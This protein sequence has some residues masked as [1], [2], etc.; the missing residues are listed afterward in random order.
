MKALKPL[1]V[2]LLLALLPGP[3]RAQDAES[4]RLDQETPWFKVE[5]IVFRNLG[6]QPDDEVFTPRM[7]PREEPELTAD[8]AYAVDARDLDQS[9][10]NETGSPVPGGPGTEMADNSTGQ[11]P[12]T[13]NRETAG[14]SEPDSYLELESGPPTL[15]DLYF[16]PGSNF[17]L[18][19]LEE[20]FPDETVGLSPD[21]E[22]GQAVDTGGDHAPV[23]SEQQTSRQRL[24]HEFELQDQAS[25]IGKRD[26][27]R[28]VAHM[29]WIQPGYSRTDAVPFPVAKLA[30]AASGLDGDLTLFLSRYLHMQF[31][32]SI[33]GNPGLD[34]LDPE[35]PQ[36]M[37]SAYSLPMAT[38]PG[39]E[40]V[41]P[42][43]YRIDERR[44][45]RSGELHYI[46]HPV[47]GVLARVSKI[48]AS[49]LDEPGRDGD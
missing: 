31:N 24:L 32:L 30:G 44:R 25:L 43:V 46:D 4:T 29:A 5:I 15:E 19:A 38:L 6:A 40:P 12:S 13:Q 16:P 35:D 2:T 23:L 28:I 9:E 45:M 27:Y 14:N 20:L 8:P 48:D 39:Q 26:M 7:E 1:T 47:F 36:A 37:G 42:P 41:Q 18:V 3:T 22:D 49:L 21:A 34:N 17:R 33:S 11:P 10:A